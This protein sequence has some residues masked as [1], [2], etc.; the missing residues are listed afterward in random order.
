M[1]SDRTVSRQLED[2]IDGIVY[3]VTVYSDGKVEKHIKEGYENAITNTDAA[4]LELN[5]NLQYLVDLA[6][7]NEEV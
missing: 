4:S 1:V 7:I 3:V 2:E 6:E 5:A